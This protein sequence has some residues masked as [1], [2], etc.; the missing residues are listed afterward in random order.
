MIQQR[1]GINGPIARTGITE[2]V[3]THGTGT[4]RAQASDPTTTEERSAGAGVDN[5][6]LRQLRGER[7]RR[8][9][10]QRRRSRF[11]RRGRRLYRRRPRPRERPPRP[12]GSSRRGPP[13][14]LTDRRRPT[15]PPG[16]SRYHPNIRVTRDD[17]V[18]AGLQHGAS[19][20]AE[21]PLLNIVVLYN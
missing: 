2:R 10:T 20:T 19:H 13:T 7:H 11:N 12:P 8:R 9:R 21:I 18:R 3:A 16:P 6:H 4:G 17:N 15:R 14:S 1:H 5:R